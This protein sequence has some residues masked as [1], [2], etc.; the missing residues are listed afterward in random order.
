M[1]PPR[2]ESHTLPH[3]PP[4]YSQRSRDI[5]PFHVMALLAA[6]TNWNTPATT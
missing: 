1:S 5:E 3:A 6:P 2:T 4:A